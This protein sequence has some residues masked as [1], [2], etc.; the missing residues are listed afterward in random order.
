MIVP[1]SRSPRPGNARIAA[2]RVSAI[3]CCPWTVHEK[4]EKTR[5]RNAERADAEFFLSPRSQRPLRFDLRAVLS[6][7]PP[8]SPYLFFL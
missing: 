3:L 7:R 6:P 5:R 4:H 8:L 2:S 1:L